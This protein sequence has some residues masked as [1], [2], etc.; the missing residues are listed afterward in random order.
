MHKHDI[1]TM[2]TGAHMIIFLF[3]HL[4]RNHIWEPTSLSGRISPPLPYVEY[5]TYN[6]QHIKRNI[7]Q[8]HLNTCFFSV[9]STL[10][11]TPLK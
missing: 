8:S 4:M 1:F 5:L 3:P 6:S 9:C 10:N 7:V 2:V 11:T